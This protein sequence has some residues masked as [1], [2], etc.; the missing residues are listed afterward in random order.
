MQCILNEL[1][2]ENS[3]ANI[4]VN[5]SSLLV[6]LSLCKDLN[7][8]MINY[9]LTIHDAPHFRVNEQHDV[10]LKKPVKLPIVVSIFAS[11]TAGMGCS[12]SFLHNKYSGASF[13]RTLWFQVKIVRIGEAFGYLKCY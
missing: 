8:V 2:G 13:I 5:G 9:K 10:K 7:F 6:I 11:G 4:V 12:H 3:S 1:M